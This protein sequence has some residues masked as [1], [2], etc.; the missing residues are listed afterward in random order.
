MRN[1]E[2]SISPWDYFVGVEA[3]VEEMKGSWFLIHCCH[4][5]NEKH[6]GI[7]ISS[8]IEIPPRILDRIMIYRGRSWET[9]DIL[10]IRTSLID[11]LSAGTISRVDL[12]EQATRMA[13]LSLSNAKKEGAEGSG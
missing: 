10:G 12:V 8:G 9:K 11:N 13:L 2:S 7:G 6:E 1:S 3:G 4:I 5:R